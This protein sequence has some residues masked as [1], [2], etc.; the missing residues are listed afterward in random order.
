ML[1]DTR[2]CRPDDAV[3]VV[4]GGRLATPLHTFTAQM[5]G[6]IIFPRLPF[7]SIR[8]LICQKGVRFHLFYLFPYLLAYLLTCYP[9]AFEV[10]YSLEYTYKH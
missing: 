10:V 9:F 8:G 4:G 2:C 6:C 3:T 7:P 5:A 1:N